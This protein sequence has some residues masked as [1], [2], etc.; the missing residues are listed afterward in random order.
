MEQRKCYK[1]LIT[2]SYRMMMMDGKLL[3]LGDMM[4]V[5]NTVCPVYV[6]RQ[7]PV[8]YGNITYHMLCAVLIPTVYFL[9]SCFLLIIEWLLRTTTPKGSFANFTLAKSVPAWKT[10]GQNEQSATTAFFIG[11]SQR[12]HH[13]PWSAIISIISGRCWERRDRKEETTRT[14]DD[15]GMMERADEHQRRRLLLAGTKKAIK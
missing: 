2:C 8:L 10:E 9:R 14:T 5:C 11:L 12:Q 1:R 4:L 3:L 6:N 15:D 7:V 13:Q